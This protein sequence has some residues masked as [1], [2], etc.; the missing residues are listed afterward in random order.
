MNK[1]AR[2]AAVAA[3]FLIALGAVA[4]AQDLPLAEDRAAID[5]CLAKAADMPE[6][7]IGTA[8][9]RCIETPEGST[10]AGMGA[11]SWRETAVWDEKM[12]ASLKQL[13]TGSL[14]Q[15]VADPSNR[16]P[17][18]KRDGKVPG[19]DIINDMQKTW[20]MFRAKKCDTGAM[21]AEGG[22]LS[23]VL[24]GSCFYDETAR[25]ALWLATLVDDTKPH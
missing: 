9:A 18:N 11:C 22:S 13:L 5:A 14:G 17:E 19:T 7:C 10:T 24:Y 15:T 12:D 21:Q 6:S 25:H 3:A 16:P 23:R 2:R 20:V 1:A 8:Y 4:A